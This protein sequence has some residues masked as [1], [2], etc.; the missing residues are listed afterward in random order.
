MKTIYST[1]LNNNAEILLD[2]TLTLEYNEPYAH[3]NNILV[4]AW[5]IMDLR[6]SLHSAGVTEISAVIAD[7]AF[8]EEDLDAL[9][10]FIVV[11]D[12][13]HSRQHGDEEEKYNGP[14]ES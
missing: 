3:I 11:S 8:S 13:E 5:A 10:Q 1:I 9:Y 2:Y 6:N 14:Q 7:V 4:S 12:K